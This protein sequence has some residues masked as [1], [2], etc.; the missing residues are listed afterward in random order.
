MPTQM[1]TMT[2]EYKMQG[3]IT[4]LS[5]SLTFTPPSSIANQA[6]PEKKQTVVA[7]E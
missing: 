7:T 5:M 1:K 2:Q 6:E 3:T 4:R